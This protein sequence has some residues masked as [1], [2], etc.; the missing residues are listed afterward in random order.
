MFIDIEW[1]EEPWSVVRRP[2]LGRAQRSSKIRSG[3]REA[4]AARTANS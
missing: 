2:P 3:K 4:L 1:L